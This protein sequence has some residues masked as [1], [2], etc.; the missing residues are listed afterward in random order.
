MFGRLAGLTGAQDDAH[1]LVAEA[2][3]NGADQIEAGL[4][5]FHD[6]IEQDHGG[7]GVFAQ[8]RLGLDAREGAEELQRTIGKAEVG[9]G[10]GA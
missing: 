8:Q 2:F 9:Q 10:P 4:L 5:G 3:A 7:V 6:H 1:E